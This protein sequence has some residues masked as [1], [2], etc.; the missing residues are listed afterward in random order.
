MKTRAPELSALIIIFRSTGPGDLAAAVA[1]VGRRGRHP[2][3]A[4]ADLASSPRGSAGFAP[5]S[6]SCWRSLPALEQLEARRIQLAVEALD[7]GER[8][9]REDSSTD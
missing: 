7:E 4:F 6:S 3:L 1:E 9:A 8:L 5:A 2:P